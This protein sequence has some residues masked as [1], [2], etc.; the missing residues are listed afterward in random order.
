MKRWIRKEYEIII[1][2]QVRGGEKGKYLSHGNGQVFL[3]NGYQ[4]E[5]E[6]WIL[7]EMEGGVAFEATGGESLYYLTH[8]FGSTNLQKG[9]QG[10]GE[11]WDQKVIAAY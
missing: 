9:Y 4:G 11:L 10:E 1:I 5:G 7:R 8:A 3:Q 6:E 2:L